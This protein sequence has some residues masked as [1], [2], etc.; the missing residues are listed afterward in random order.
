MACKLL[1]MDFIIVYSGVSRFCS[2]TGTDALR[3]C[4]PKSAVR[5]LKSRT[6]WAGFAT[7]TTCGL[8]KLAHICR[9]CAFAT[10]KPLSCGK[11][12]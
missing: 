10:G 7:P 6:K 3:V 1:Y 11:I 8:V 9:C 4:C 5:D 12:H 2:G